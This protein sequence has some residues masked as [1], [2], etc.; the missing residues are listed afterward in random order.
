M[1]TFL[2]NFLPRVFPELSFVCIEHEGKNNLEANIQRRLRAWREPGARFVIVR[3][4]DGSDCIALK[5]RLRGLCQGTGHDD[6]LIRI[7]CQELEAW[8]L[9]QPDTMADAFDNERLRRI[10]NQARYR[11][12]DAISQPSTAIQRLVPRFHKVDDARRM[13]AHLTREGNHSHSFNVFMEGIAGLFPEPA[14]NS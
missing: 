11:D 2:D 9:G 8:Y 4:N 10:G 12:P 5:Q 7:V 6:A 1:K 14:G 13:A 3:D